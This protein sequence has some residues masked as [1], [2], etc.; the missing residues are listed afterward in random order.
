M[1]KLDVIL[2]RDDYKYYDHTWFISKQVFIRPENII[3]FWGESLRIS[4]N[5]GVFYL[6]LEVKEH[7]NLYDI[8]DESDLYLEGTIIKLNHEVDGTSEVFIEMFPREFANFL[9][10]SIKNENIDRD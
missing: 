7:L 10:E 6:N 5:N 4:N 9:T 8:P 1:I 2:L 3:T